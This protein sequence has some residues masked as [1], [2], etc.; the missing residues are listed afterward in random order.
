[1]NF[2]LVYNPKLDLWF[3]NHYDGRARLA[4]GSE[5]ALWKLL[6]GETQWESHAEQ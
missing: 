2:Y 3:W 5:V 6:I 4:T 1:M